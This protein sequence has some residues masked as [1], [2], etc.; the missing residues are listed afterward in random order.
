MVI[1]YNSCYKK[2]L[3]FGL[4]TQCMREIANYGAA[5][6]LFGKTSG[7]KLPPIPAS[8]PR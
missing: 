5:S 6:D 2:I 1:V 7:K 8:A 3:F 4:R